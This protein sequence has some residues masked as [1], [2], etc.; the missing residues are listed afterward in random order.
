MLEGRGSFNVYS[1]GASGPIVL[2]I[3]GGGYT[4][5]TW[6]LLAEKMKGSCRMVAPDLRGHGLTTT[7]DGSHD[8]PDFS[9]DTMAGDI[10]ALWQ[11][12]FGGADAAAPP[13]T[14]LVGHSMGGALAVW[15]ASTHVGG[16]I[17]GVEGVCVI[18]VVEGTALAA[19]P[20]MV[21]VLEARPASFA[22]QEEAIAWAL[23]SGMCKSKEAAC[24]SVPAQVVRQ[25]AGEQGSGHGTGGSSGESSAPRAAPVLLAS[26]AEEGEEGK[27]GEEEGEDEGEGSRGGEGGGGAS[28]G[29][30]AAAAAAAAAAATPAAAPGTPSGMLPPPP[31]PRAHAG[32][33]SILFSSAPTTTS[34]AAATAG[35]D[36]SVER[37]VWRTNLMASQP[38]WKGWYQGLS[39]AF[40]ALTA[41][42]LLL[43][44]GSDRLDKSLT[45]GQM[46]GKFQ[47]AL[48]PM[49]G[50]AVHE[51]EAARAADALSGFMTRFRVGLPPVALPRHQAGTERVLPVVA[52]PMH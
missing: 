9:R 22:S 32:G 1:A 33:E 18:D 27:E 23:R 21:G 19:L 36:G 13:P 42:K 48:L 25:Q 41:P 14:V 7:R 31:R 45:I 35:V 3:H 29:N 16:G 43:L 52:G 37:W 8:D 49:A 4:G 44:A 2:C 40:L 39:D 46:Q 50:H 24:I 10:V 26:L 11:A 17:P 15:A 12:I 30:G 20:Y 6:S 28:C 5:L 34:A 51:D 47:L 38:C